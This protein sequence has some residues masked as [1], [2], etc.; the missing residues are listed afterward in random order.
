MQVGP[1]A[2][3]VY[4]LAQVMG[5]LGMQQERYFQEQ[6]GDIACVSLGYCLSS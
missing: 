4:H 5:L 3:L 6:E 2:A 1:L